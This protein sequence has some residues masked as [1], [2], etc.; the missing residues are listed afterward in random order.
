[1]PDFGSRFGPCESIHPWEDN[2][3]IEQVNR[4][5]SV[6]RWIMPVYT[7]LHFIPMLLFKRNIVA[8]RPA[9][10]LLRA[11]LGTVRSSAFLGV[12]VIIY[13]TV[14]CS[15]AN[16]Y[17]LFKMFG[18][19]PWMLD[20]IRSKPTFWLTG[21]LCGLSL[22]VEEPRRRTELAMYVLPKGMESA[23]L[24][25]RNRGYVFKTGQYGEAMVRTIHVCCVVVR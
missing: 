13:Q 23:W 5:F 2:C 3:S 14:L 16:G 1:M 12:F 8:K 6:F 22:F 18:M 25:A 24:M 19:P 20:L 11:M 7:A 4:F 9:A 21:F 10:M 15:R 17:K